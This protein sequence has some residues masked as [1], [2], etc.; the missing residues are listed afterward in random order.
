MWFVT[1]DLIRTSDLFKAIFILR[2]HKFSPTEFVCFQQQ[3]T[4]QTINRFE[5]EV[6][7]HNI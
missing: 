3:H 4:Q 5:N 7:A 6:N 2:M 1:V